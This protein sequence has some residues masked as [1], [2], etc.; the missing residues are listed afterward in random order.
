MFP[1]KKEVSKRAD[2]GKC[3]KDTSVGLG[4]EGAM[5]LGGC[6][7]CCDFRKASTTWKPKVPSE[8]RGGLE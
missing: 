2:L 4:L 8:G 7:S 5:Y 3:E 6:S 1:D